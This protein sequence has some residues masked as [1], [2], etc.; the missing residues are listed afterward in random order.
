MSG[1][2][3]AKTTTAVPFCCQRCLQPLKL[4]ASFKSIDNGTF[5]QLTQDALGKAGGQPGWAGATDSGAT[6]DDDVQKAL[7]EA[8]EGE[9]DRPADVDPASQPGAAIVMD[10]R[11]STHARPTAAVM[12]PNH[13]ERTSALHDYNV[14]SLLF[15]LVSQTS[16][17]D[18]PLCEECTDLLLDKLDEELRNAATESRERKEF[19]DNFKMP[20]SEGGE[21][22]L[23][24][25]IT[26]LQAEERDL[27]AELEELVAEQQRLE[28]EGEKHEAQIAELEKQEKLHW[29]EYND[30]QRL[31]L[32]FEEGQRNTER[33]HR[34]AKAQLELLKKTNVFNDAFHIWYDGHFGTIN[35][36]RLGRLPAVPVEWNE[37]N[38]AWGHTLLLLHV[39][40][41]RLRFQFSKFR[42]VPNGSHSRLER[43][44]DNGAKP[45]PLYSI[46]GFKL[47]W[48][49]RYDEAMVAFLDCLHEFKDHVESKDPHFKLPYIINGETIGDSHTVLSIRCQANQ[50]E[51]WTKSLKF[52]LTN[53]KWC[54]AWVCKQMA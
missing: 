13:P 25:E 46:S 35:G 43:L 26:K 10:L 45:L 49:S 40:A 41:V 6:G 12:D 53:L 32:D 36:F 16:D 38:A 30:N 14:S 42:L 22:R 15:D 2:D 17:V 48:D 44:D 8:Q 31:L 47:F 21:Q 28:E 24:A 7:A 51:T 18:H 11:E 20:A 4:E 1:V 3:G 39:M 33:R 37:I 34:E 29:H 19:L 9:Q 50:E 27:E 52:M 54:L 5:A 23:E